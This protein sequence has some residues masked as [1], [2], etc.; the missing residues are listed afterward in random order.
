MERSEPFSVSKC[1]QHACLSSL[2]Q[3]A[4]TLPFGGILV[5]KLGAR[6]LMIGGLVIIAVCIAATSVVTASWQLYVLWGFIIGPAQGLSLNVGTILTTRF[7]VKKR[8]LVQGATTAAIAVGMV[9]YLAPIQ[10]LTNAVGWRLASLVCATVPIV[11]CPVMYF[12]VRDYP[13]DVGLGAYGEDPPPPGTPPPPPPPKPNIKELLIKPV[14]AQPLV[15]FTVAASFALCG[16][17]SLGIVLTHLLPTFID[18]G[19][20]S[21]VAA[22]L[23]TTVGVLNFFGTV[24]AGGLVDYVRDPKWMCTALYAFRG[25]CFVLL[26]Q[27]ATPSTLKPNSSLLARTGPSSTCADAGA[28][29]RGRLEGVVDGSRTRPRLPLACAARDR[30]LQP[31]V[32][33]S[34]G[35]NPLWLDVCHA[36]VWRRRRCPDAWQNARRVRLVRGRLAAGRD[37]LLCRFGPHHLHALLFERGQERRDG[38]NAPMLSVAS[39]SQRF[40]I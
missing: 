25:L 7:F 20:E 17:T 13:Y 28:R 19:M 9:A 10:I 33:P 11:V 32:G 26:P 40:C 1:S 29:P 35:P 14:K 37:P 2:R 16:W 21:T 24:I 4:L 6:K 39:A 3:F 22:T 23:L 15:F 36:P 12:F 5:N 18:G 38:V 8:G 27:V 31:H 30:A 34:T